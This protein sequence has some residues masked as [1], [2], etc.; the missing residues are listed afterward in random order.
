MFFFEKKTNNNNNNNNGSGAPGGVK[1][2]ISNYQLPRLRGEEKVTHK[3]SV[4]GKTN[5]N[6]NNNSREARRKF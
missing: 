6:N 5:N 3:Q 1:N 4:V 2:E